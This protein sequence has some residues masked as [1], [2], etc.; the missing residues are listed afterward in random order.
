MKEDNKQL[1]AQ[2]SHSL[3]DSAGREVCEKKLEFDQIRELIKSFCISSLGKDLV[4][5]IQFQTSFNKVNTYLQQTEEFR[6]ILLMENTFPSQDYFDLSD[7]LKRLQI[8][9]TYIEQDMLFQ[10]KSSLKTILDC[11]KFL[12]QRE[13]EKY[14]FLRQLASNIIVDKNILGYCNRLID[15]R[16]NIYDNASET[17]ASIRKEITKK[18]LLVDQKIAKILSMA[19]KEGWTNV[20]AETTIR[21][22]RL[23]IP[24][25]DT[26]RRKIKGFIHDESATR[27]TAYVE[28]AEIVEINNDLRELE[29]AEKRE[30]IRILFEFSE[31]VRPHIND[32]LKA[33]LFLGSLDFIRSKALFAIQIH[34]GL[35]ILNKEPLVYW[36]D[37]RHPLLYLSHQKQKKEIVPLNIELNR[38]K[39]IMII[40]GPNAGGKSVCLKTVGL[41]QYMLQCGLL[42]P[43]RETSEF[44]IFKEIFIDIGDEQSIENDL[45]TYSSHLLNMNNLLRLANEQTL[46]LVDELGTGTEPKVGGAIAEA[47][48]EELDRKK[49]FGIATTHYANLKLLADRHKNIVNAA[50]LF[51]TE[52]MIPL[53]RLSI[54]KPGS[55]FAFEIAQKIGLPKEVLKNAAKKTGNTLLNFENQLQKIDSEKV[56]L[57]KKEEEL[58]VADE[59]LSEMI[60]K[61]TLLNDQ[62]ENRKKEIIQQAKSEA[63]ELVI[64]ANKQIENT[65]A[66]IKKELAEKS[67]TQAARKELS[68]FLEKLEEPKQENT[69]K[70]KEIQKNRLQSKEKQIKKEPVSLKEEDNRPIQAGDIVQV[71]E[72][73]NYAQVIKIEKNYAELTNNSVKMTLP[74]LLLK[75]TN[76]RSIPVKESNTRI[77]SSIFESINERKA[78]FSPS[79]DLRGKRAEEAIAMVRQLIDDALLVNERNLRILH[80]KGNG[81]LK[82]LIREYLRGLEEVKGFESEHI[83]Q[84]GEGVTL[85]FLKG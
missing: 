38:E 3:L 51:D 44:G 71:G 85:V 83:E 52:N 10:M 43:A 4:D 7:E 32:L 40:S 34:A 50:M 60:R 49:S 24:V 39:R 63:K 67:A 36:F 30:I 29:F 74:L 57:Q 1:S 11:L 46:F 80:G 2:G 15:E 69:S 58:K 18:K 33:Y 77:N 82:Q 26:H 22:G 14:P 70:P 23:V 47:I 78:N 37:A 19:K 12:L 55:S 53:Y 64:N 66:Q 21:N 35:P 68:D 6:Q 56:N 79:I 25:S 8:E 13:D 28:P 81:I 61:Y 31:F 20:E 65:I 41:L 17:L 73:N 54:G 72:E 27:Q 42:V 84:G 5:K 16:G 62:L 9:G 59:F 75:K 45:S 76:K 48:L